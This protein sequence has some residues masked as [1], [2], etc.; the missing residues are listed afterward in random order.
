MLEDLTPPVKVRPCMIRTILERLDETDQTILRDALAD[1][2]RWS[3][4]ALSAALTDKGLPL[5]EK[6]LRERRSRPCDDCTCRV[7]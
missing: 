1:R 6:I 5:G 3:N 7:G 2:E 4:R